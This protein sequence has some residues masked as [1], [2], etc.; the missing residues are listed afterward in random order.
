MRTTTFHATNAP[1]NVTEGTKPVY[2]T[3]INWTSG[4]ERYGTWGGWSD[5]GVQ[6]LDKLVSLGNLTQRLAATERGGTG[7]SG[8]Q[9]RVPTVT[10]ILR[11][12]DRAIL[13]KLRTEQIQGCAAKVYIAAYGEDY[14]YFKLFE[15]VV[16]AKPVWTHGE[17]RFTFSSGDL[18]RQVVG[19]LATIDKCPN[20][21]PEHLGRMLPIIFGQVYKVPSI[22]AKHGQIGTM[23]DDCTASDT[24]LFIDG[25]Q[26][27]SGETVTLMIGGNPARERVTGVFKGSKFEVISRGGGTIASGTT[28]SASDE[29]QPYY[30]NVSDS[31]L[32]TIDNAWVGYLLKMQ[33]PQSPPAAQVGYSWTY[34]E[35]IGSVPPRVGSQKGWG[36]EYRT[37]YRYDATNERLWYTPAFT[38]EDS[39]D[40][41]YYSGRS[42]IGPSTASYVGHI[43]VPPSGAAYTITTLATAHSKGETVIELLS[44]GTTYI[45]ADHSCAEV[46]GVFCQ[47]KVRQL[48]LPNNGSAVRF[49]FGGGPLG[50]LPTTASDVATDQ[51]SVE[52]TDG[53]L[54]IPPEYYT[55]NTN[56]STSFP[57]LGHAITT[58]T[59]KIPTMMIPGY[60]IS[61]PELWCN[62]KG[63]NSPTYIENP[64]TVLQ[65]IL[66]NWATR[67]S[68]DTNA[69]TSA[70]TSVDWLIADFAITEQMDALQ[71]A[72]EMAW[73]CRC[74][75]WYRD[76]LI[77]ITFLRNTYPG[78][79]QGFFG[80]QANSSGAYEKGSHEISWRGLD[81][82][83]TELEYKIH[84]QGKEAV[85][86][87]EDT[88]QIAKYGR[89]GIGQKDFWIYERQTHAQAVARFWLNRLKYEAELI[90]LRAPV[91]KLRVELGDWLKIYPGATFN[92][93]QYGEVVEIH[94]TPVDV[95]AG[96]GPFL[97]VT[98]MSSYGWEDTWACPS[99]EVCSSC[100][101][102]CDAAADVLACVVAADIGCDIW[103]LNGY[104]DWLWDWDDETL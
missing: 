29:S 65:R 85:Y 43:W 22:A 24:T 77:S 16:A 59:F 49:D 76:G 5:G 42:I 7:P 100:D 50:V 1:W 66:T 54:E 99:G 56:D 23:R 95:T 97:D 58:I 82:I 67:L 9:G 27:R 8:L 36:N 104:A 84:T 91:N 39:E 32:G 28:Q 71:L 61:S 48:A 17:V 78:T 101:L 10:C 12:D 18:E 31:D 62:V 21:Y 40:S 73:Q 88:G 103:D 81:S 70:A 64:V 92:A 53:F 45:V 96:R 47:G 19:N 26:E 33:V 55:I 41:D 90:K 46:R 72:S 94:H 3:E 25:F 44:G 68:L 60:E 14:D 30:I 38:Y 4:T 52:D 35:T 34:V 102:Y 87:E 83:V 51:P 93:N 89:R 79:H 37:I 63:H 80:A 86:K 75:T 13:A 15:G 11:D 57:D 2:I 20:C 69:F 98:T 6:I 74:R